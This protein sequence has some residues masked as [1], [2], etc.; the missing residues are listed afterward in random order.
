MRVVSSVIILLIV[1]SQS[2]NGQATNS[3]LEATTGEDP[4][5]EIFDLYFQDHHAKKIHGR[6]YDNPYPKADV[7]QFFKSKKPFTGIIFT[8]SDTIHC[9]EILYDLFRDKIIVYAP[10]VRSYIEL[11]GAFILQFSLYDPDGDHV[12]EFTNPGPGIDSTEIRESGFLQVLYGGERTGLY[13]R[14][15]KVLTV[16]KKGLYSEI[17]FKKKE[18]LVL[19][20]GNETYQIKRNRDLLQL[21]PEARQDI[22]KF[23]RSSGIYVQQASDEQIKMAGHF[24]DDVGRQHEIS[25]T[26][27]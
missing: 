9:T 24:L 7:H 20:K 10:A 4:L 26:V 27:Q 12:Y 2:L 16:Y 22:R 11:E 5:Q 18:N 1:L 15:F 6:P 8:I 13:K 17:R 21:Y 3:Y 25:E 19:R 14:H 23:L